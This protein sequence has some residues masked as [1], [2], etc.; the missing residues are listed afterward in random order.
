MLADE[1]HFCPR[2]GT[3][4]TQVEHF[5]RLRPTCPQ[6]NWVYFPDPKVAAAALIVQ[7]QAVLLVARAN[8]PFQGYW[9][10]PAGFVDAGE[11]PA[12]AV[13]RECKEETGLVVQVERLLEVIAGQEHPRGAHILIVY[14]CVVTGG[15]LQA[16]DDATGAAFFPLDQLP[17]LAFSSTHRIL[18][19]VLNDK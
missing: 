3:A 12:V 10:L 17:E 16:G 6:C 5:G 14:C 8:S 18:R 2:C 4:V 15:E 1:I 9:T 11:D 19:Q 13:Q 7:D